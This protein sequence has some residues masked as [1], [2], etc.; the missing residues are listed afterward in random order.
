MKIHGKELEISENEVSESYCS[1][2]EMHEQFEFTDEYY[3]HI[4][5][6]WNDQAVQ[7]YYQ[8]SVKGRVL[9]V[10]YNYRL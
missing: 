3:D 8:T 6:L 5:A 7:E 1:S 10:D 2:L 9:N 4:T